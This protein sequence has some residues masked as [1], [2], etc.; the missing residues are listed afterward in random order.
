M[1]NLEQVRAKQALEFWRNRPP[2][3]E[4][5]GEAGGDALGGL[6]LLILNHGLLAALALAKERPKSY[7]VILR[8][9]GRFLASQGPDGRAVFAVNVNSLETFIEVLTRNDSDLLQ[10]ATAESLAYLAYLKRFRSDS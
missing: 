6:A 8:E 4:L 5:G 9:I 10:L 2:D 7:G 1:K 3:A